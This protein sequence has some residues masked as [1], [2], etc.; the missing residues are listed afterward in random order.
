MN[1]EIETNFIQVTPHTYASIGG[2]GFGNMGAIILSDYI[3]VIDSSLYP[4]TGK[5]FREYLED[6]FKKPVQMLIITHHHGDHIFGNQSFQDVNIVSSSKTLDNIE[7]KYYQDGM[8]R[9]NREDP[10]TE[11]KLE[12]IK[13][14]LT[15][16]DNLIIREGEDT[17]QIIHGGGHTLGSSYVYYQ[18]EHVL[19]TGDLLFAKSFPYGGDLTVNPD[20]WIEQMEKLERIDV[21]KVVPGH[22]LVM[23]NNDEIT[24]AKDLLVSIRQSVKQAVET[25]SEPVFEEFPDDYKVGSENR[26]PVTRDQWIKFYS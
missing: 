8:D 26:L 2:T 18:N 23:D 4:I 24:R 9:L 3:I 6:K 14:N 19:F 5:L 12:I 22:G 25:S 17:V 7:N 21:N 10:L 11:G 15:F 20:K 1:S 16:E 13:P